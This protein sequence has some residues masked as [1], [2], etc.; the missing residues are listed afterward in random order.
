MEAFPLKICLNP[1]LQLVAPHTLLLLCFSFSQDDLED[2]HARHQ[3]AALKREETQEH[4]AVALPSPLVLGVQMTGSKG[5]VDMFGNQ[6]QPIALDQVAC[7]V[8]Q[9]QVAAGRFAP[10]LEKCMGKG[11]QASRAATRRISTA[12]FF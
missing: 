3:A 11:R 2:V 6:V 10:H 12:D 7:P 4:A 5:A 9:R 8:C 1:K